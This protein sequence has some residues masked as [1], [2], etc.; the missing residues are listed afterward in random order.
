MAR[1]CTVCAHP[2]RDAIDQALM[3][4]TSLRTIAV[5]WSVSKTALVRHKA[6]HIPVFLAKAKEAA[7]V[8]QA[9]S[10]LNRLLALSAETAA[11]L[12]DARSEEEKDN[13]LAL[14]A[15]ARAEKQ[16]ELQARLLGELKEGQPVNVLVMP[17]WLQ[18]RNTLLDTLVAYP[19]ARIAVAQ[20]L[21]KLDH[22]NG[23][24]A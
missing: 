10:L 21:W 19:D 4:E 12:K 20:A 16:I 23:P 5:Q 6:D 15:I 13:E 2:E 7:E 17:V 1:K 18:I 3:E 22:A 14:R 8:S 24:S 9:D 11:I